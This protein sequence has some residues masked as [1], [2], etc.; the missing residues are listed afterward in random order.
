MDAFLGFD[1]KIHA[2]I[3]VAMKSGMVPPRETL[4]VG[5]IGIGKW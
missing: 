3:K 5:R 1:E 4:S 2:R